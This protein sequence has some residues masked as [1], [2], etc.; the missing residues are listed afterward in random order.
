MI[1]NAQIMHINDVLFLL[2]IPKQDQE[3]SRC[4]CSKLSLQCRGHVLVRCSHTVTGIRT[5]F[6]ILPFLALLWNSLVPFTPYE[7]VRC[8]VVCCGVVW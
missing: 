3:L 6:L 1:E 8:N 7:V 5:L 4:S 2:T